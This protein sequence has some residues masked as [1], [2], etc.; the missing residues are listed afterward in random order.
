MSAHPSFLRARAAAQSLGSTATTVRGVVKYLRGLRYQHDLRRW[1]CPA[2]YVD[3]WQWRHTVA[4]RQADPDAK[5]ARNDAA[6]RRR[7]L[8]QLIRREQRALACNLA[9]L[10]GVLDMI[11]TTTARKQELAEAARLREIVCGKPALK[12]LPPLPLSV[13]EISISERAARQVKAPIIMRGKDARVMA[14]LSRS[15]GHH[16]DAYTDWSRG[17]NKPRGVRAVHDNNVR[18]VGMIVSPQQLDCV[19]HE[20]SATIMLP[21]DYCWGVDDHGIKA[22]RGDSHRDDYHPSADDL[23]RADAAAFVVA[24]LE[25]NRQRRLELAAA[26]A[27]EAAQL[28]GVWVC[29]ADSIRAGNCR[30]GTLNFA[31]RHGLDPT[32]HYEAME[33]LHIAN[34]DAGRVRLVI[35][36]AR[37]RHERELQQGF[38]D[39][40]DHVSDA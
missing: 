2:T 39:L 12:S 25:R 16:Q 27:A 17:A 31:T 24:A 13:R 8:A 30:V 18:S 11:D 4:V 6:F 9:T 34:G 32:R 38:A 23:L 19:F 15:Y 26:E 29:V 5:R 7:Y 33:L 22:L 35:T 40:A 10:A 28:A 3:K 20:R 21:D 1:L 36:A 37:L 14:T